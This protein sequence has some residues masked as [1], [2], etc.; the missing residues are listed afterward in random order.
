MP[1]VA[2]AIARMEQ[3]DAALPPGDGVRAFNEL[4]L[5]VS[6]AVAAELQTETFEDPEFLA[7][8]QVGF[9]ARYFEAFDGDARGEE[10]SRAWG[11]LFEARARQGIAPI[12]F[13]L[14]GMNAHINY[15]LCLALDRTCRDRDVAPRRDTPQY[16]DHTRVNSILERVEAEVKERFATGL[17]GCADEALGR[18]DDLVAMWKVANA[19]DA[20]WTGAEMLWL[21]DPES[22]LRADYLLTLSR[23]VGF[24]GRGLLVPVL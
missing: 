4:Y 1:T 18:L 21:L 22:G 10:V 7:A 13:A 6:R 19:R 9:A 11:P 23:V 16:R 24:A 17:V 2:E 8:L 5:A 20:A 12:Q 15:D 14:G 3:I